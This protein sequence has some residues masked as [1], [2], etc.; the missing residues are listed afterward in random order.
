MRH[1]TILV[2]GKV[3][4]VFYRASTVEKAIELGLKGFAQN[5]PDGTVLIEAEGEE[6]SLQALVEWCH[7]GPPRADV[8]SVQVT[9]VKVQEYNFFTIKR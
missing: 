2:S 8:T 4:G 3:Q 5:L 9:E 7:K 6:A 1:Y